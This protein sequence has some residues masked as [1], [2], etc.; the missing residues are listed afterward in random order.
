MCE[1]ELTV[2]T[3]S[4]N[5]AWQL[6]SYRVCNQRMGEWSCQLSTSNGNT[7][8]QLVSLRAGLGATIFIKLN[9]TTVRSSQPRQMCVYEC[10]CGLDLAVVKDV[11]MNAFRHGMH[12][13][14][15]GDGNW[16]GTMPHRKWGARPLAHLC[17]F[18]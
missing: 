15:D 12:S 11:G 5:I 10:V 2:S 7:T 14:G 16:E 4:R 8:G 17:T 18:I 6:D 3:G 1:R 9:V 13:F